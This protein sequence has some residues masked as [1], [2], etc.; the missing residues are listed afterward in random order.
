MN[1]FNTNATHVRDSNIINV[2]VYPPVASSTLLD[3]VA[4][5][6]AIIALKVINA[7]LLE[8]CFIPKKV[9]VHAEVIV[10]QAP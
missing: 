10:G 2:T 1:R 9:D 3:A 4:M 6:E 7:I 8:K 5:K